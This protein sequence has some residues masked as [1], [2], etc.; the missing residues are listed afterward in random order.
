MLF[1]PSSI[2]KTESISRSSVLEALRSRSSLLN[3]WKSLN[4]SQKTAVQQCLSGGP[5]VKSVSGP[6]GTGKTRAI[7][8]LTALLHTQAFGDK[9]IICCAQ[10]NTAGSYQSFQT[11]FISVV[12]ESCT[13]LQPDISLPKWP[14]CVPVNPW[15]CLCRRSSTRSG[16]S[17][18]T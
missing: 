16:T 8:M 6:P 5:C 4:L 13:C 17:T 12:T 3:A 1:E 7:A 2:Y 14:S 11:N 9:R 15:A 10:T 18:N